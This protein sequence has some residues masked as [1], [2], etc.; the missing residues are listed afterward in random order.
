MTAM[1]QLMMIIYLYYFQ[2]L[3]YTFR[4][5]PVFRASIVMRRHDDEEEIDL[6]SGD[7]GDAFSDDS[8][9]P[10][11]CGTKRLGWIEDR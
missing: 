3:N 6:N 1:L 5:P 9:I 11:V 2:H 4:T 10:C 7:N 8:G